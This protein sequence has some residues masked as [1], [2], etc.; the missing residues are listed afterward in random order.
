MPQTLP[1]GWDA[2]RLTDVLGEGAYGTVYRACREI[3]GETVYS[4]VKII[5]VPASE[6]EETASIRELGSRETARDYYRDMADTFMAEIRAMN[7][8]KGITN[9]VSVEDC[10]LQENVS[11]WRP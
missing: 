1:K 2:W 6:K 7:A 11:A 10:A 4:A 3:G 5:Q 8:L 9:I